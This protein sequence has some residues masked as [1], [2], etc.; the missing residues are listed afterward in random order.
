M[1]SINFVQELF[2]KDKEIVI[3]INLIYKDMVYGDIFVK[4]ENKMFSLRKLLIKHQFC[5]F[6]EDY[7]LREGKF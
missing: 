7:F 2:T 3:K 4:K 6:S 5:V 1:E